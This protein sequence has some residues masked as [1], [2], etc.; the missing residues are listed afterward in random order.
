[1]AVACP[2]I[3][4]ISQY[5]C[6]THFIAIQTNPLS[7][8]IATFSFYAF[9]I[10]NFCQITLTICQLCNLQGLRWWQ[11]PWKVAQCNGILW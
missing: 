10:L 3:A 6:H 1:M 4:M 9:T 2:L 11:R 5:L 7:S 8:S